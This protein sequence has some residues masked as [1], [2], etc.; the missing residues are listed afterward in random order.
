MFSNIT[1]KLVDDLTKITPNSLFNDVHLHIKSSKIPLN[2]IYNLIN[3]NY[4]Y[5]YKQFELKTISI[6]SKQVQQPIDKLNIIV[7]LNEDDKQRIIKMP[8]THMYEA[9]YKTNKICLTIT[10]YTPSPISFIYRIFAKCFL[11]ID[12]FA[13]TVRNKIYNIYVWLSDLKKTKPLNKRKYEPTHVNSGATVHS[14]IED[15]E[16][17]FR[18]DFEKDDFEKS[19]SS[20]KFEKLNNAPVE[21]YI[22]RKEEFE[23]VL[24]HELIHTLKLDFMAYPDELTKQIYTYFNIPIHINI[25]VGEA[26]VET[27]AMIFNLIFISK[28]S[29][30]FFEIFEKEL[31]FSLY[32]TSKVIHHFGY[33]CL[34]YCDKSLIKYNKDNYITQ[35]QQDTSVF[36]YYILKT[37]L[38]LH[39]NE[40]IQ[41]CVKYNNNLIDFIQSH[42]NFKLFNDILLLISQNTKGNELLHNTFNIYEP[43]LNN[44]SHYKQMLYKTMRMSLFEY[45]E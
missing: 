41:F 19:S 11:I 25:H 13:I 39:I 2:I 21:L 3:T 38:L 5:I 37:G 7:F 18:N 10:S 29:N 22:W 26:Y 16:D 20:K 6:S 42:D 45:S 23:K 30:I 24:I 9:I 31:I 43:Y 28:S 36:S 15:T 32:Q 17:L 27:W 35:F 33:K 34:N 4:E 14:L 1:N 12:I 44:K 8:I 40:F